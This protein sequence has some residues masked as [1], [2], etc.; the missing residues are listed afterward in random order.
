MLSLVALL[1]A[2]Q[3]GFDEAQLARMTFLPAAPSDVA[4]AAV[5]VV[6]DAAAVPLVLAVVLLSS[7]EPQPATTSTARHAP[8]EATIV[9]GR[10][11]NPIALLQVCVGIATSTVP[12]ETTLRGRYRG[13]HG[14]T[15]KL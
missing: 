10:R 3:L 13:N 7:S 4:A 11:V 8:S 1:K 14:H 2:L 9:K 6:D 15:A 12:R 5:A